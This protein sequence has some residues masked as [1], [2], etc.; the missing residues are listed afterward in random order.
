MKTF[1]LLVLLSCCIVSCSDSDNT[2]PIEPEISMEDFMNDDESND[3]T[4]LP[5]V[6]NVGGIDQQV[7]DLPDW[8]LVWEEQFDTN[9]AAWA[10][11]A[12]WAAKAVTTQTA[13]AVSCALA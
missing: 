11:W 5:D 7:E 9:L 10:A 2:T 6:S 3:A 1:L 12:A 13:E 8:D 4:I